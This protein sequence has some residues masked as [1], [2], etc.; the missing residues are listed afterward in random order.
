VQ[1]I[2]IKIWNTVT[3]DL[4]RTLIGHESVFGL[5]V[6]PNGYLVSLSDGCTVMIW[7]A[8]SDSLFTKFQST[9][10]RITRF[11]SLIVLANGDLAIVSSINKNEDM[12]NIWH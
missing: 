5:A 7:N 1:T 8:N 12:I 3:G 4:K 11:N 6:L 2:T 9:S 10:G